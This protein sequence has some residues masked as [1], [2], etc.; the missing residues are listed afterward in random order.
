[1]TF[2]PLFRLV[3]P[4][5][6]ALAVSVSAFAEGLTPGSNPIVRD[7]FS[8]APAATVVGNT[9]YLYVGEDLSD[10]GKSYKM[11][12]WRAYSSTDMRHW[13][14]HGRVLKP[15]DFR[16]ARS[17]AYASQVIEKHGKFY[18]YAT[19]KQRAPYTAMAIG[20]AVADTPLGPF[21]DA[22]GTPLITNDMTPQGKHDWSDIDP[23]V[24]TDDD[25]TSWL[26]WG[27]GN[28]FIA[29]L[30]PNMS[31]LDG[32][33]EEVKLPN[34]TEAPWLHKRG[35]LY[36]LSYASWNHDPA[37]DAEDIAY[38][39]APS[40]KGPWTFRGEIMGPAKNSNTI[41]PAI[42]EFK[43]Q[44]YFFYHD[45]SWSIGSQKGNGYRRA[46]RVERLYYNSDGTIRP[47][48]QTLEGA[49]AP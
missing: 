17:S 34:Y 46:V 11:P 21:V 3:G 33:I 2:P 1:M 28:C 49:T 22:R 6:L 12:E 32:P 15:T 13:V 5:L 36:Y 39:T 40:V 30:K 4:S 9:V 10:T 23:T 14:S 16:W 44:W 24:F 43:G 35:D 48:A 20:V 26:M 37:I 29:R 7:V 8:A 42:I 27:N 18:F 47:M 41:H 25:G 31:E 38:A 19:A 45:G